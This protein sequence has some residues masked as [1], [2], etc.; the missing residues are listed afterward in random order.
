LKAI[1]NRLQKF[2]TL[3]GVIRLNS[4]LN[5][6]VIQKLKEGKAK[7]LIDTPETLMYEISS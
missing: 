1:I 2:G 3:D 4:E 5:S 6:L 7:L